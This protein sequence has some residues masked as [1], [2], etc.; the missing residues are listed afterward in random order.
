MTDLKSIVEAVRISFAEHELW[1]W[2][3]NYEKFDRDSEKIY[4]A[5]LHFLIFKGS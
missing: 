2:G 3:T 4:P 1:A 5:W